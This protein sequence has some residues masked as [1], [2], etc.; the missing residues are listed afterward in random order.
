MTSLWPLCWY[1]LCASAL[2]AI[3]RRF[4]LPIQIKA[5]SALLL[6]PL[7]S[8]G[9]A[10]LTGGVYA[11]ID[12]LYNSEPLASYRSDYDLDA[13]AHG[14]LTDLGSQIVPMREAVRYAMRHGEWPLWN[15]FS[16][17]GEPL[18]GSGQSGAF[19]W[20][21][22]LALAL[23]GASSHGFLAALLHLVAATGLFLLLRDLECCEGVALFG[24]AAFTFSSFVWFF[25]GW[26]LGTAVAW[27]PTILYALRRL[28]RP[29]RAVDRPAWILLVLAIS[30]MVH[31]GHPESAV[32]VAAVGLLWTFAHLWHRRAHS[33]WR[34]VRHLALAAVLAA[35][36]SAISVLPV[37]DAILQSQEW[38]QRGDASWLRQ[39]DPAYMKVALV[40]DLFPFLL[41]DEVVSSSLRPTYW[42]PG[43]SLYAGSLLW[44]PVFLAIVLA[45]RRPLVV[46]LALAA[47][48]GTLVAAKAPV[49]YPLLYK[50]P[51]LSLSLNERLLFVAVLALVA[52]AALGLEVALAQNRLRT[53]AVIWCLSSGFGAGLLGLLWR[54]SVAELEGGFAL[55]QALAQLLP[56]LLAAGLAWG[57]AV[58]SRPRRQTATLWLLLALLLGQR[59][60]EMGR[61]YPTLP[62][63]AYRAEI[64][65]F[66]P[67]AADPHLSRVTGWGVSLLP[68]GS[69]LYG[70]DDPRSYNAVNLRRLV[71]TWPAWCERPDHWFPRTWDLSRPFL[72]LLNVRYA[73]EPETLP[74][75]S[76]WQSVEVVRGTRLIRNEEALPRAFLPRRVRRVTDE[77]AALESLLEQRGFWR[78]GWIE[79]VDDSVAAEMGQGF[80]R[81]GR[82]QVLSASR[83]GT[84]YAVEVEM[85]TA[86]WLVVTE[87]HFRGWR[88]RASGRDLP[89]AYAN[90]A[91][92]GVLVPAGRHRIELS[93]A[94]LSFEV[95]LGLSLVSLVVLF[96]F[97]LTGRWRGAQPE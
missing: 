20:A 71:D 17:L 82:G 85:E 53:L 93:Y 62:R 52:L 75:A 55:R 40:A 94:P 45:W 92:L 95:G 51:L 87:P 48:V 61:L 26:P 83:Q 89:V 34:P 19:Y 11:P 39:A 29:S 90:H 77:E 21:N 70:L 46:G 91:F 15:P 3:V 25:S 97:A 1:L 27:L 13:P 4:L 54:Q 63:A 81:N 57:L 31:A 10:L 86:G 56:P 24:A 12:V 6:L 65:L 30:Q 36:L 73:L 72:D 32:H 69:V 23:P 67:I 59:W 64:P 28:T 60:L 88:A 78:R 66:E 43:A 68:N 16:G 80:E 38:Q 7:L 50:L 47:I 76:G 35:G 33:G 74:L 37:A 84:G 58:R 5:A 9:P 18:L 96:G 41:G 42:T 49:I 2:L 79:P 14:V 44:A 22:L 8:T